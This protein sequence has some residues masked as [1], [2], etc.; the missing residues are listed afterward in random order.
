MEHIAA[1][2]P[3]LVRHGGSPRVLQC[4]EG[5]HPMTIGVSVGFES[6][7]AAGAH[8]DTLN[9]D[10]DFQAYWA[11]VMAHPTAHLVRSMTVELVG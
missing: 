1:S 9:A 10:A 4:I 8:L 7:A 11:D 3:H 6:L 2:L 5:H